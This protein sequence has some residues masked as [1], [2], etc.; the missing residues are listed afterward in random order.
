VKPAPFQYRRPLDVAEA[1][2]DLRAAP[3]GKLL[4]GGQSLLAVMN[5]RLSRPSHLIDIGR[6]GELDRIFDDE[7]SLIV[8]ALCTHRRLETDPLVRR[9]VPLLAEAVGHVGHVS[10]RNQGTVGGSVAH[11]DPAAEL[12]AALVALDATLYVDRHG[13]PRREVPAEAFFLSFYTTVLEPAEMLTWIRVPA[14][15]RGTTWGFAEIARRRGDFA[16][17]G[18]AVV[19][20]READVVRQARCVL[21]G[22]ADRPILLDTAGLTGRSVTDEAVEAYA[23]DATRDL[24]PPDEPEL[25]RAHAR[26]CVTRA[27]RDAARRET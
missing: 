15:E 3:D 20:S 12:P 24:D 16:S 18:A 8:G 25:R 13:H 27:L 10:I 11:A 2:A 17:A 4:A 14:P 23:A 7:D 21:F 19:L 6:L 9:R 1:L 26:V 5:L 22:V